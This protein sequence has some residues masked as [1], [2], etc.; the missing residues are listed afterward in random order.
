MVIKEAKNVKNVKGL[1]KIKKDFISLEP[2]L[3]VKK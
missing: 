2:N 3:S 1:E